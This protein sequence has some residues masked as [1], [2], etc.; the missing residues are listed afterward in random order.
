MGKEAHD[1]RGPGNIEMNW[2]VICHTLQARNNAIAAL[3]AGVASIL[4][5]IIWANAPEAALSGMGAAAA[6]YPASARASRSMLSSA[7]R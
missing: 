2:A 3:C 1:G 5:I 7:R 6:G 4:L